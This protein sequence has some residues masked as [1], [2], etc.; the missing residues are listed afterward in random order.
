MTQELF[1][2]GTL[3]RDQH[4]HDTMR[5][6]EYLAQATTQACYEL[7]MVDYYPAL[8]R[9]GTS[10]VKGELYRVD[11]Q[12]LAHLDALEEVPHYYVRE[13]ITL[14]DGRRVDSY[15]MPR[16]RLERSTP[17]AGGCFRTHLGQR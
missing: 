15:V 8:L 3:M 1:V 11:A 5:A 13:P 14:S 6:A 7:V 12:T 10:V 17:I 2:Y 4:H 9:D 16:E